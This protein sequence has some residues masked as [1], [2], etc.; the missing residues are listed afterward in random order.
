LFADADVVHDPRHLSSLVARLL[1]LRV[2]LVSEMVRL[3]CTSTAERILIP[4][5]VYFFQLLYPFA[6]VNRP[7]S[8]VAAAAGGTV[9]IRREA[10]ERIGGIDAIKNTLIDDVALAKA[11]K[12]GGPVY[13]AH[14]ALATSIRQYPRFV[15]VWRMIARTAFTQLKFS[16]L[17]LALTII[18]LVVAWLV[19]V[20]AIVFA[21][22]WRSVVGLATYTLAAIS[23]L[24][25]LARYRQT[26]LLALACAVLYGG[27]RGI[28]TALLVRVR[29]HLEGSPLRRGKLS[30][31]A[32]CR[33][34]Q[35][36]DELARPRERGGGVNT[37]SVLPAALL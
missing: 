11:V 2:D 3:N 31:A 33:H 12:A 1:Q 35:L 27:N 26:P 19:P 30:A 20:W 36:F 16:A 13:L 7:R 8:R 5:F 29:R 6:K 18:G 37:R 34:S 28:G 32:P 17:V 21:H 25:T 22:D 14:S 24:P 10:L 15:D 4:A 9:M 23:Y